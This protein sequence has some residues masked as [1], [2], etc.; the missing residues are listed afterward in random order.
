MTLRDT[1][2]AIF[3]VFLWST[4]LLVQKFAVN[5]ISIYVLGFLRLLSAAPLLLIYRQPPH[6]LWR[7]LVAGFFWNVLNFLFIGLG[8]KAG[9]GAGISSFLIQTNVF[10][11]VFFC[12]ILLRENFHVIEIIGMFIAS[13][14]VYL[15]TQSGSH[16]LDE[17]TMTGI[18]SILLSAVCWG[19]G[20]TLLKKMK[21]GATMA[22]NVWLSALSAPS[23]FTLLFVLEGPQK[24]IFEFSHLSP[25]GISCALYV[26]IASTICASYLWLKLAH[27]VSS[28]QQAPFMLLLPIFTCALSAVFMQE[29]LAPSQLFAGGIILVGVF[30]TRSTPLLKRLKVQA[31]LIKLKATSHD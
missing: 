14:G 19:I 5:H 8:F 20:F 10:F 3:V 25:V 16:V 28:S 17:S 30:V 12:Y 11:G 21:I 26:G 23:L 18:I 31:F 2:I 7:Y 13:Y 24:T 9:V 4:S 15:L 22:D 1:G 29:T 27:R 6:Q